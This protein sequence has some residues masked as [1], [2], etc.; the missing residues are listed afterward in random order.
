MICSKVWWHRPSIRTVRCRIS[1]ESTAV[2]QLFCATITAFL[3]EREKVP[4]ATRLSITLLVPC[5]SSS[6]HWRWRLLI[7]RTN[8]IETLTGILPSWCRARVAVEA[9]SAD[10]W[11]K[12]V[13]LDGE[14]VGM[15]SFGAS[16]PAPQLFEHFGFTVSHAV[17]AVKRVIR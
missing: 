5:G 16:A 9:A 4:C 14:V 13:G 3:S 8:A 2:R 11:R 1:H 6:G 12:Y 10:Y 17:D 15:T 7:L